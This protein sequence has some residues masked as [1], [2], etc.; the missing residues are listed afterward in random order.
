MEAACKIDSELIKIFEDYYCVRVKFE[1]AG[2]A[3]PSA[4]GLHAC[5][6]ID[7]SGSMAGRPIT[8]AK[9]ALVSFITKM[10]KLSIPVTI[11]AFNSN[12]EEATSNALGYEGL[13]AWAEKINGSGGT[14]FRYVFE[15]MAKKFVE[16]HLDNTFVM[17]QMVRIT[18]ALTSSCLT[19]KISRS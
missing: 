6:V 8:D 18:K 1:L 12:T 14:L 9:G 16:E 13:R 17:F 2:V 4:T 3:T 15:R 7:R 19:W 10:E 11:I 5:F